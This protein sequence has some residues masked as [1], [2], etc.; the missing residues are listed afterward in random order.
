MKVSEYP[1]SHEL[2]IGSLIIYLDLTDEVTEPTLENLYIIAGI[3]FEDQKP[4]EWISLYSPWDGA[5]Y[6]SYLPKK[7]EIVNLP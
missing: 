5:M 1:F 7:L 6:Y 4:T 2:L 3:E